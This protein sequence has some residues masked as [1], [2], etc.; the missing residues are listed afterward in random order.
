MLCFLTLLT[1]LCVTPVPMDDS[2]L[3]QGKW[4]IVTVL[5]NGK[6]MTVQ[7]ISTQ[8]VSDGVFSFDGMVIS[9]IPPGQFNP[10]QIP[11]TVNSAVSPKAIDLMGVNKIGSEGIYMLSGDNLM[12]SF[13]GGSVKTRPTDF[14][15]NVGSQSVL[16]VL[17]RVS[18]V[19]PATAP[20]V[21]A[22]PK[23]VTTSTPTSTTVVTITATPVI[24]P[25]G[26][27][28]PPIP[29]VPVATTVMQEM[30]QKL[31]GT[32]GHQTSE[33]ITYY[34]LNADGTFS[35]TVD[36][37]SGI[38]NIFKNDQRASGVWTLNN[39][40]IV[41]TIT[42][43]TNSS[44]LNQVYSWRVTNLGDRDLIAVDNTGHLRHEWK[45]R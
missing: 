27:P 7:E 23:P 26:A 21:T 15:N 14:S 42:A 32:W 3:L 44:L 38:S 30:R 6:S 41:V 4:K 19:K 20:V 17:Q 18:A 2:S 33:A 29:T 45:V 22:A 39:G 12:L 25:V 9:F 36:W 11:F 37:K 28:L 43:S 34:T 8:M 1:S 16:L 24:T 13:P 5:E 10:K 35:S 31:I 40:V